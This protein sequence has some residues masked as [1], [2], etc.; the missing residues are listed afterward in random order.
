MSFQ[1]PPT[2]PDGHQCPDVDDKRMKEVWCEYGGEY[3]VSIRV[4]M[5]REYSRKVD[6]DYLYDAVDIINRGMRRGTALLDPVTEV[7]IK[8]MEGN[9][10]DMFEKAGFPTVYMERV[11]NGYWP[12]AYADSIVKTPWFMITTPIGHF[13]V[14]WRKSVIHFNWEKTVLKDFDL[15]ARGDVTH[16]PGMCHAY[17][18]EDGIKVLTQLKSALEDGSVA[19]RHPSYDD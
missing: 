14:G 11:E 16:D 12:K 8:N 7:G 18:Y 4:F 2:A 17:G 5:K 13:H 1:P 9:F 19:A 10:R 6:W 15:E 3:G